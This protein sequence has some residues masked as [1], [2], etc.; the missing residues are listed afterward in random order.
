MTVEMLDQAQAL[1][2]QGRLVEAEMLYHEVL[3]SQP[4][5]ITA[6]NA[7]GALRYQQG[8]IQEA[9]SLFARGV[10]LQPDAADFRAN[11]G[12]TLRL[13]KRFDEAGAHLRRAL[14]LNP[15][16][17][18]AWNSMGLLFYDQKMYLEAAEAHQEA[19]RREP[20]FA[21]GF[22]NLGSALRALGRVVEAVQALR[23][24]LELAP[25]FPAALANLGQFLVD[26]GDLTQFDEAEA[27]CRRAVAVAPHL[28]QAFN[29]LGNVL[30]LQGRLDDALKCYRQALRSSANDAMARL[31]IGRTYQQQGRYDD[32]ER[33]YNEAE[34]LDSDP[35]RYHFCLGSLW[36]DRENDAE[37]VRHYQLAVDR[38][39]ELSLAYQGLGLAFVEKGRHQDAE[40]CLQRAIENDPNLAASWIGLSRLQ[41]ERG[42]FE[43]SCRSARIALGI[44]VSQTGAH[45]QLATN[46]RGKLP[47]AE[48]V[49]MEGLLNQKYLDEGARA[50]LHF[51]L[52]SVY[53][54]RARFREASAAFETA[55]ALKSAIRA[56][57]GETYDP[58][59]H[60]RLVDRLIATFTPE[61]LARGPEWR[62]TA[63]TPVF[64]VGLPRSGTS[65]TEQILASHPQVHG[66]GELPEL[67]ELFA[68]VPGLVG[69]PAADR[70]QALH[71][72]SADSARSISR[73]YLETIDA[74]TPPNASR[75]VD[76]MPENYQLL[77]LIAML[78]PR[79]RVIVCNRNLRDVA[80]S[81]WQTNF[82]RLRWA[83]EFEHI[84]RRFADY[85]R[86]LGHWRETRPLEWLDV[87][88]EDLVNDLDGQ[89]RR[90][91]DFVGLPWDPACLQFHSARRIVRTASMVQVREP[92]HANSI[93]RWKNYEQTLRPL[94]QALERH[95]IV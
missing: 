3:Q 82:S 2:A 92:V 34:F 49:Q 15:G 26:L 33:M 37:A 58:D 79:S 76:K 88:Y 44:Q 32:A 91:I 23:K 6:I 24:A 83:N 7:L 89:T 73:R 67:L 35:A 46:L 4:E 18:H 52:G 19:I 90:L 70:C 1:H 59:S 55:N 68:T 48:V 25:D 94:F 42:D 78:W 93:G 71:W 85:L 57:R 64:V 11:L 53:D 28:P 62:D 63:P 72:L 21:A 60:S 29:S 47:S 50:F 5:K 56:A 54:D 20:R 13:L 30:R 61:F 66:A 40:A 16:S 84:A 12:E 36:A 38:D 8:R 87:S 31:N 75:V 51:A 95:G 74:L 43:S 27:I 22:V 10:T 65:L 41:A 80:V 69:R 77:G 17:H 86:L 39:P 14:A 45:F 81:C 9:A